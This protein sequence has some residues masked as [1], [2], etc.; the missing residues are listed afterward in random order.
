[1]A[2]QVSNTV[3]WEQRRHYGNPPLGLTLALHRRLT[4]HS[5]PA[6][7]LFGRTLEADRRVRGLHRGGFVPF[8]GLG[9][10]LAVICV[11]QG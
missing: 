5:I 4:I 11:M 7:V 2:N 8:Q 10:V 1:M 9:P 6:S 3:K